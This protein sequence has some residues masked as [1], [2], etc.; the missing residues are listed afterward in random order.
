[1]LVLV[2][3]VDLGPDQAKL[4]RRLEIGPPEARVD[5]G[6]LVPGI[7][8]DEEDGIGLV[9]TGDRRVEQVVGPEVGPVDRRLG[10]GRRVDRQVLGPEPVE[11][12]LE[13]DH[14][15]CVGERAGDAD[16]L[17]PG[18]AR[19]LE[20]VVDG[21]EGVG[22]AGR[23][24]AVAP[25][26]ERRRQ[27]LEAEAVVG[28]P[29]LVVDPLFIEAVVDARLDPHHLDAARVDADVGADAVEHVDRLGLLELPRTRLERVRL[30]RERPDRAEVD[31]IARHLRVHD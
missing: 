21:L 18:R 8:P 24:K 23:L 17:V 13:G 19:L 22:P 14:R 30:G 6:R 31:N 25:L 28:V 3:Q 7:G 27:P 15:L 9:E 1:V 12:V 11:E 4:D 5:D 29:S 20:T 16:D 26:D 2:R 10:A